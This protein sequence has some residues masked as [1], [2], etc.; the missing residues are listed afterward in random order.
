M[1]DTLPFSVIIRI[2]N[3]LTDRDTLCSC[4]LACRQWLPASRYN[5]FY[6]VAISRRSNFDCLV[7][8][9][10][11]PHIAHSLKNVH[12]LQLWEDQER[13][14]IHL[15][16]LLFSRS[17]PRMFFLTLGD[18]VWDVFPLP[19]SFYAID[20]HL[21]SVTN[22]EL[23]DGNFYNFAEFRRL[24]GAFRR[25]TRLVV[26]NVGWRVAPQGSLC[27]FESSHPRLDT[28][29][30]NSSCEGA[31]TALVEWLIRTPSKTTLRDVQIWQQYVGNLPSLQRFTQTLGCH[32]EYFQVSLKSWTRDRYLD[33]SRNTSLRSLHIRDVDASSCRILS[34]FLEALAPARDLADLALYLCI[35]TL[36]AL[37]AL[38][39]FWADAA[40]ALV[41][42][43][44]FRALRT[45]R[46]WLCEAPPAAVV[47]TADLLRELRGWM[48]LLETR[49]L[50]HVSP[51]LS[52]G[53]S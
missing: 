21:P 26:K 44:R 53:A 4:A 35:P 16:P 24:V 18:F 29:W 32:L 13:P 48:R 2:L 23:I 19:R 15:F 31:V 40:D 43:G 22:L 14:W 41:R 37:C 11:S 3:S 52:L 17:L 10:K 5:L 46:V 38:K 27:A 12:S 20:F 39:A 25:L 28:L 49:A 36:A 33:L 42:D 47:P 8:V 1:P 9:A 7:R 45:V 30:F 50:V 51:W 34:L 6:R